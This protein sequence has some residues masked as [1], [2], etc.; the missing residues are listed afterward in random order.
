MNRLPTV[1][2]NLLA[3]ARGE[4]C[5]LFVYDDGSRKELF[6][7]L[8]RFAIEPTL[9]FTWYDAAILCQRICE[10]T[11]WAGKESQP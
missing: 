11:E 7:T 6:E 3:L 10:H 1:D 8:C 2:L 4:D 9:N 5:Y